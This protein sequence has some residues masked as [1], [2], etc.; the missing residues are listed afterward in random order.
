MLFYT[1]FSNYNTKYTLSNLD[2]MVHLKHT[3]LPGVNTFNYFY[4]KIFYQYF[5]S[6]LTWATQLKVLYLQTND[7]QI[8][9]VNNQHAFNL[10]LRKLNFFL[11]SK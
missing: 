11:K 1:R 2:T 6:G 10:L 5:I 4:S 3:N 8:L 7:E 9:I